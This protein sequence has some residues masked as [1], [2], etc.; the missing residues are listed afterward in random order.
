MIKL[1]SL[2]FTQYPE[3][4][5]NVE[6]RSYFWLTLQ[7]LTI[8]L[9]SSLNSL[10]TWSV[11]HLPKSQTHLA[12]SLAFTYYPDLLSTTDL[13]FTFDLSTLRQWTL[14]N[15]EYLILRP[16]H[17]SAWCQSGLISNVMLSGRAFVT[18]LTIVMQRT[19]QCTLLHLPAL[20][21]LGHLS[22]CDTA[23]SYLLLSHQTPLFRSKLHDKSLCWTP[24]TNSIVSQLYSNIK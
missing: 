7:W 9:N 18:Q 2:F 23:V 10:Q 21:S 16:S 1:H 3:G 24:E 19:L 22:H 8:S 12:L 17:G 14:L 6:V 13:L 15:S 4:F 5:Y 11:G 20:L